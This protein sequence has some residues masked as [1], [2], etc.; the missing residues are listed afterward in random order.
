MTWNSRADLIGQGI[1]RVRGKIMCI[2]ERAARV[3][4]TGRL[5]FAY[6]PFAEWCLATGMEESLLYKGV[7]TGDKI[8]RE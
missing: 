7:Q 2:S 6:L 8:A 3:P 5:Y 1:F 4:K